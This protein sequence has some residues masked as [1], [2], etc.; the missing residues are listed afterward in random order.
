M[1]LTY[2]SILRSLSI[3]TVVFF[4]VYQYMYAEAHFPAT[5]GMYHNTYFWFNQCVGINIAMPMFSLIAGYL[6]DYLYD[7]GKYRDLLPL[8][9][10]KTMRL[11]LPYFVFGVLMMATIGVPFAPWKLLQGNFAHLWYLAALFWCFPLA[12]VIKKYVGN[13]WAKVGILVVF[14]ML[15]SCDMQLPRVLGLHYIRGWFGWFMLGGMIASHQE[16]LFGIVRK[17]KLVVLLL[18][19]FALQAWF[20]PVEYGDSAWYAVPCTALALIGI[21]YAFANMRR[22][23]VILKLC[24]PLVWLSKYSFGI[25]L[26]HC[27]VGPYMISR[28]AK[29]LLPLEELA[30]DHVMLFPLL[31]TL[32][33]IA[34]SWTLTW[35]LMKTRMGRMLVG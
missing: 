15:S 28:T 31:L 35:L 16:T 30:A 32:S 33:V 8:M 24:Q 4:H 9:R 26:F 18:A 19:P 1:K 10:K 6:F 13:V 21:V 20:A 25:Y 14:L 2:I 34:V 7:R 27:W 23:G 29:R 5:V 22:G 11:W 17:Y 3:L 12:W